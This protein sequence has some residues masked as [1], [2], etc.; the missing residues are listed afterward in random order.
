MAVAIPPNNDVDLFANDVG[1]IAIANKDGNLEGF[2]VT[3]GGGMGVTH[4]NK[5]TYP[6]LGDVLGFVTPEQ[7]FDVAREILIWQRDNGNRKE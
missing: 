7:A 4:S 6:R 2:N 1:F 3:A 5:K